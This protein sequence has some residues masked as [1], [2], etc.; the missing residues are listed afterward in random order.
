MKYMQRMH[1]FLGFVCV[2]V[3]VS[4]LQAATYGGGD[5]TSQQPYQIKTSTDW[6][7]LI[8]NISDWDK[9]FILTE[10]IDLA[11][12]TVIPV[13]NSN[14][15][16]TGIFDGQGHS[17]NNAVINLP[18]SDFVGL[19]GN[20]GFG[21]LVRNMGVINARIDG[22]LFIGGLAGGNSGTITSCYA[23]GII[24]SPQT[25]DFFSY[26]Y[27]GGLVGYNDF[28]SITSCY[29]SATVS[30]NVNI[31]GL[32]GGN[33]HGTIDYCYATGEVNGIGDVGG[34]VGENYDGSIVSCFWNMQTS[35]QIGSHGGKGLSTMQ[36]KSLTIFQNAEWAT[37]G[38][39]MKDGTDY[40][41]LSWENTGNDA[42]PSARI[43]FLGS[44]TAADPYLITTAEEFSELSWYTGVLDKHIKL[45]AN[46]DLNEITLY[47]IGDLGR[48]SGVFDGNDHVIRNAVIHQP[49]DNNVGVFSMIDSGGQIKNL[50]VVDVNVCGCDNVGGLAGNSQE[51]LI[52]ACYVTGN[53]RGEGGVGG[54]VGR[55]FE[56]TINLCHA[57]VTVNASVS[58]GGLAGY[59]CIS[60]VSFCHA[61]GDVSGVIYAGG[62][63]GYHSKSVITSC[64][65]TGFVSGYRE[66]GGFTGSNDAGLITSCY[67]AGSVTGNSFVGGLIGSNRGIDP[68][69]IAYCYS[70]GCVNGIG[71]DLNSVGGLIGNNSIFS[72][73]CFWDTQTSGSNVGVGYGSSSGVSGLATA[74]MMTRSTFTEAGWD[75]DADDGDA[76]DWMMLRE[77]ED[78][79]RLA[80]QS[81]YAGDIAG[82]YGVDMAD[83]AELAEHWLNLNCPADCEDADIDL[84]GRVDMG[85]L[86]LLSSDWLQQ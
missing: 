72:I 35:G 65:A 34:L 4:T 83:F 79:P 19:F 64:Y 55:T 6:Q 29:A 63:I 21:G 16:F 77:G 15:P 61:T 28:G 26:S 36:M 58:A 62:L 80:W 56:C 32:V 76:A 71:D 51:A 52:T 75:F 8:S 42:I 14:T 37:K 46:L 38:W 45:I 7:I 67:A 27:A 25:P 48:F 82:L 84:S 43:P 60:T 66:V 41:H 2:A 53:V 5:G 59:N 13:G 9:Q 22:Q 1:L 30:G 68:G 54:L 69:T 86:L 10:N 44:G 12:I 18:G 81:V 70:T 17:I 78:Y 73:S 85:D 47:P 39:V 20:I 31:G 11:G 74:E 50:G 40:P 24:S 49:R 3:C 23:T 57:S 33:W